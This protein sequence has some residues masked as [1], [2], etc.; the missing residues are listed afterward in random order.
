MICTVASG[1]KAQSSYIKM[2]LN[3]ADF[4]AIVFSGGAGGK[5]V[6]G[7][8]GEEVGEDG[9]CKDSHD[10]NY[11]SAS[12]V[13]AS[14]ANPEKLVFNYRN[15]FLKDSTLLTWHQHLNINAL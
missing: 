13:S 14:R 11:D 15:G 2:C 3:I 6:W 1:D 7:K 5:G 8:P 12:E 10:P 9:H 4:I